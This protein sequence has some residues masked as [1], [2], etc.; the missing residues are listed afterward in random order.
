MLQLCNDRGQFL[1]SP[2]I[3]DFCKRLNT[4]IIFVFVRSAVFIP[5]KTFV[6]NFTHKT[7]AKS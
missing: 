3:L 6:H 2:K 7:K 1:L 5:A 4:L